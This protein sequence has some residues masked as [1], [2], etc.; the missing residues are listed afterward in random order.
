MLLAQLLDTSAQQMPNEFPLVSAA[1][2]TAREPILWLLATSGDRGHSA[3]QLKSIL[4]EEEALAVV[5]YLFAL[6]NDSNQLPDAFNELVH[7]LEGCQEI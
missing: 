3:D 1:E 4:A 5:V 6:A 7:K 2:Q